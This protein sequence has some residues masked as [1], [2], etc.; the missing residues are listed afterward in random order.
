MLGV[1]GEKRILANILTYQILKW[2]NVGLKN[3]VSVGRTVKV[4]RTTCSVDQ[5][6]SEKHDTL[7]LMKMLT[8]SVVLHK[9]W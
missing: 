9:I 1:L 2:S 5:T 6:S 3:P 4:L 8:E 7:N